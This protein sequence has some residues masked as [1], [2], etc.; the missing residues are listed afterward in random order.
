MED[1]P[2]TPQAELVTNAR[3]AITAAAAVGSVSATSSTL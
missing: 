2:Q 1:V 3:G